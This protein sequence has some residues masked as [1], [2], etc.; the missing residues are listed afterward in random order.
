[1]VSGATRVLLVPTNTPSSMTVRCLASPS[2]LQVTVPAPTLTLSPTSLS[3]TQEKWLTRL[4]APT[5]LFLTSACVPND[6]RVASTVP[7]RTLL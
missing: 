1:M 4:S 3:S 5:R 6:T 2:K 7:G